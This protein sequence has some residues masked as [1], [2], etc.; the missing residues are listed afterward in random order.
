MRTWKTH[1]VVENQGLPE[2]NSWL[3]KPWCTQNTS[4]SL[5]QPFSPGNH[6]GGDKIFFPLLMR[7]PFYV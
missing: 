2:M 6:V 4:D 5:P 1:Y 7:I 3:D